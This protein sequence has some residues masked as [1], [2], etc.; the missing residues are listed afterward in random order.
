M[1][2]IIARSIVFIST[3]IV[4]SSFNA[5]AQNKDILPYVDYLKD[6]KSVSAKDY[7]LSLFE[8]NDLV[9][10]CERHHQDTTQ[11]RLFLE[12]IS[13][14]Y[15][16]ENVGTVFTEVGGQYLNPDLNKFL[17]NKNL[18]HAEA[19]KKAVEFQ[20]LAMY[21]IWDKTNFSLF[22]KGIREINTAR[23]I[24]AGKPVEMYP[25]DILYVDGVPDK[26]KVLEMIMKMD[27]RDTHMAA[28]IIE[29]FNEMKKA[30]PSRKALVIMNYRHAYKIKFSEN[31]GANVGWFLD[32]EYPGKVANVLVNTY[33]IDQGQLPY[34]DG[35]WDA[36]FKYAGIEN[37]GF[38][39]ADTPFGKDH[40]DHWMQ[41]LGNTYSDMFDG[42]VFYMPI[43][44]FRLAVGC[45]GFMNDGF[46]E[47]AAEG[48]KM[49]NETLY[50][51]I[52]R[53]IPPV[54]KESLKRLNEMHIDNV[55]N[56]NNIKAAIDKWL[57]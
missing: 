9:I 35:K 27:R 17:R 54:D 30:D 55:P 25:S 53:D 31:G 50:R 41:D 12:V 44:K 7:I 2:T 56:L 32:R 21:P 43:E 13:D 29:K 47:K 45:K 51:L 10:L 23:A 4:F 19:E 6:K 20:R 46:Y 24:P 3:C 40:F 22:I 11:Y 1:R 18:T 26:D 16:I 38:G 33:N 14:P 52:N 57:E 8:N 37:T 34:Q 39:F 42:F 15:F 49:F 5:N 36:A 48:T 28:Y